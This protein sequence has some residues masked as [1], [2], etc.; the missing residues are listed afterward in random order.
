MQR[1]FLDMLGC[2]NQKI[3]IT[4][5]QN[6]KTYVDN[7]R[8]SVILPTYNSGPFIGSAI[9][10]IL[11][12]TFSDFEFII[13]DDCSRDHTWD[14]IGEYA[15]KDK[16]II[17]RRNDRNMNLSATLNQGIA[18]ARGEYIARM[19]HDDI[20]LKQRLEKQVNFLDAHPE[21]GIVGGGIEI[22]DEEDRTLGF[23]KYKLTDRDIREKIFLYSPFC[24][25]ATVIRKHILDMSGNYDVTFAPADDYELYFRLGMQGKFA[26][27][28]DILLKYRVIKKTSM[29]TGGTK[30][31]EKK[32]IQVRLKYANHPF[33][34]MDFIDY[35]YTALHYLSLYLVSSKLKAWCFSQLRN[36]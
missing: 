8:V 7:P 29:T 2:R 27:L 24:H 31:M 13:I 26:N 21:V 10:S 12:Q 25:P 30:N 17:A 1:E 28:Q 14:R 4:D 33:Y 11:D 36:S 16:R 22:I 15:T 19:D 9:E 3:I 32:T 23:R 18:M 35:S 20:S 34:K 5:N 6:R